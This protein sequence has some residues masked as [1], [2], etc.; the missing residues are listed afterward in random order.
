M[1][2]LMPLPET[3][4]QIMNLTNHDFWEIL[5][6]LPKETQYFV[7]NSTNRLAE[8]DWIIQKLEGEAKRGNPPIVQQGLLSLQIYL[9]LTCADALGHVYS[10]KNTSVG[11][12]FRN[13]FRNLPQEAK[14]NLLDN[15]FAWK[16]DLTNL[17]RVGLADTKASMIIY[18]SYQQVAQVL[19][20]LT[21]H[22][23]FSAIVDFLYYRRNYYTHQ[24]EY[25]QLG[26]HPNLAVMQNQRL[27]VPNTGTVGEYDRLEPMIEIDRKNNIFYYFTYYS[28]EDPIVTIR[29]SIVRGL[30]KIIGSVQ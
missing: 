4:Y 27:N 18:P 24:S 17:T 3:D 19:Q 30:G 23:K 20:S 9:L 11:E 16:T 10:N 25:P 21:T 7:I 26:H 1:L 8:V 13:F 29:W 12:R 6:K 5:W 22:D 28:S 14:Q 15:I 2:D